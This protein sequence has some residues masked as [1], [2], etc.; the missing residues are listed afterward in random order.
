MDQPNIKG[1]LRLLIAIPTRGD[2][3]ADMALSLC[4]VIHHLTCNPIVQVDGDYYHLLWNVARK[5]SSN[6]PSLRQKFIDVAVNSEVTHLLFLDDDMVFNPELVLDWIKEGRPVIA[7]NCPTKSIPCWPTARQ[8]GGEAGRPVYS[9]VANMRY[10]RVWRVGTGIMLLRDS[11]FKALPRP[12]FSMPWD[13]ERNDYTGEDWAMVEHLEKAGI[14]VVVDHKHSLSVRHVGTMEFAHEMV[15]AS[16]R[17]DDPQIIVP[18]G[19]LRE[20]RAPEKC[21]NAE[22]A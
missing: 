2:F 12:A 17:M 11:A 15:T 1:E 19:V 13:E 22:N 5:S 14:P 6:L 10:E 4:W 18:D 20:A 3:K 21:T 7:A 8:R 9:D 16:R